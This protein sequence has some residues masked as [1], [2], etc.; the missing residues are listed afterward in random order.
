[1]MTAGLTI[2]LSTHLWKAEGEIS[3]QRETFLQ[4]SPLLT[5]AET[6]EIIYSLPNYPPLPTP[7]FTWGNLNG[8]SFINAIHSS[9]NEVVHW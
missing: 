6:T 7:N 2:A 1:M 9:Y 3:D 5:S 4:L 8:A